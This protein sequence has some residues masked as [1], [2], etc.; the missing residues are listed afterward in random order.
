MTDTTPTE[1]AHVDPATLVLGANARLDADL[2]PEFIASIKQHGV[3]QTIDTYRNT[4]GA[5]VVLRGQRRTLAAVQAG[6][7]SVPVRVLPGDHDEARRI[8][9]QIVENDHR[10]A[11]RDA[12]RTAAV[13]QLALDF[14]LSAATIAKR[15]STT[16][17]DVETTLT[18][19]SS[20]ISERVQ[21]KYDLT[22]DQ[23]A[24]IAEFD[25]DR[26]A[27][28]ALT[29]TAVKEPRKFDHLAQQ[30]RDQRERDEQIA[31]ARGALVEA[32]VREVEPVPYDDKKSR[33][34]T[35]LRMNPQTEPG[36][37]IDADEHAACPGHAA[38]VV[39]G[40]DG[41]TVGY[42]CTDW[43]QHGH[44]DR[45]GD[46]RPTTGGGPMTD[47]QRQERR[48]VIENNKA[49]RSA[50]TVRLQWLTQFAQRQ[51]APRDAATYLA[52]TLLLDAYKIERAN[53]DGHSVART[54][55]GL[56]PT[57]GHGDTAI[58]DLIERAS[59]RR[60]HVIALVLALAATEAQMT[61]QTWRST[62]QRRYFR[63]L[64]TWGY[65]LSDIESRIVG[66]HP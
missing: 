62:S 9:E 51:T 44:V 63:A 32:G 49:W 8:V 14:G 61:T 34:L 19:A 56:P 31:A 54:L 55:L 6:L 28:K 7:P 64:A 42:V 45:Y 25:A 66:E 30:L 20:K 15:T 43:K 11:M 18:V 60:A 4:D 65:S 13:K 48:E 50:T 57:S 59:G 27:V 12:H 33:S 16:K 35:R 3:L 38:Y 29:A 17:K 5:L 21:A 37:V 47:E 58:A 41:V 1:F 36:T 26:E 52:E 39:A 24:V 40:W 46:N 22:L 2:T 23:A 10:A 53:A